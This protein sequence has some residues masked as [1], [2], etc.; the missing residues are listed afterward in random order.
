VATG[1]YTTRYDRPQP[2]DP[3]WRNAAPDYGFSGSP[4]KAQVWQVHDFAS[5][6][7]ARTLQNAEL[8]WRQP[9]VAIRA[10]VEAVYT[11]WRSA[12]SAIKP[13]VKIGLDRSRPDAGLIVQLNLRNAAPEDCRDISLRV[14]VGKSWGQFASQSVV[15]LD[16]NLA[17]W[18]GTQ[19]VWF[20]QVDPKENWSVFVE[21]VGSYARTPDLQYAAA[22]ANWRPD[23]Q[24]EPPRPVEEARS[25]H[26]EGHFVYTDPLRTYAEF[27]GEIWINEGGTFRAVDYLPN[28]KRPGQG[29]WSFDPSS[30]RISFDWQPGGDFAGPVAGNTSDFTINGHWSNGGSGTLRFQRR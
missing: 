10:A 25:Y 18:G 13:A 29:V 9:E 27:H 30:L 4:W 22:V 14:S 7:A 5:R 8:C 21:A 11:M 16:E 28:E 23:P 12:Y 20:V 17:A 3:L 15:P 26:F 19:R 2:Y 24:Q 1:G 6:A